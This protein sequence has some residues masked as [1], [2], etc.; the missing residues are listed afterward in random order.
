M[1]AA[2]VSIEIIFADCFVVS[3]RSAPL[4]QAVEIRH[5]PKTSRRLEVSTA[6]GCDLVTLMVQIWSTELSYA[7]FN[8]LMAANFDGRFSVWQEWLI[9]FTLTPANSA[10]GT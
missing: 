2:F 5:L 3:C 4:S 7:Q 9:K 10:V 6:T 8:G 1:S